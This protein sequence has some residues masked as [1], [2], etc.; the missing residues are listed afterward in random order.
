M[1]FS[2]PGGPVLVENTAF[3]LQTRNRRL[4]AANKK[5]IGIVMKTL[6]ALLVLVLFPNVPKGLVK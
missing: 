2:L 1:C 5:C 6:L 3:P 4:I